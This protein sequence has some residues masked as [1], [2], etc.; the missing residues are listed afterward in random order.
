M[1]KINEDA[2]FFSSGK[3]NVLEE[4]RL[5]LIGNMSWERHFVNEQ[6]LLD[7]ISS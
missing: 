4:I 6:I 3:M 7:M 5:I 1:L 2:V